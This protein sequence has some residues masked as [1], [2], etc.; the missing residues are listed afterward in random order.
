MINC[1]YLVLLSVINKPLAHFNHYNVQIVSFKFIV[2]LRTLYK[3]IWTR[4]SDTS[5]TKLWVMQNIRYYWMLTAL[6]IQHDQGFHAHLV[7]LQHNNDV[8]IARQTVAWGVGCERATRAPQSLTRARARASQHTTQSTIQLNTTQIQTKNKTK[9][10]WSRRPRPPHALR[11]RRSGDTTW[12]WGK[13]NQ[14]SKWAFPV[15]HS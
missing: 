11:R 1:F 13:I 6:F 3:I 14:F 10:T 4:M 15:S 7:T 12:L 9:R 5:R 8:T 2:I